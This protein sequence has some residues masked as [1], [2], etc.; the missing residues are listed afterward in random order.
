MVTIMNYFPQLPI[1]RRLNYVQPQSVQGGGVRHIALLLLFVLF[2]QMGAFAARN[3]YSNTAFGLNK[4]TITNGVFK[5]TD[6]NTGTEMT[7]TNASYVAYYNPSGK[8]Y[9][10]PY[11]RLSSSSSSTTITFKFTDPALSLHSISYETNTGY[12]SWWGGYNNTYTFGVSRTTGIE[13][14][15]ESTDGLT[16]SCT[17]SGVDNIQIMSVGFWWDPIDEIME[18]APTGVTK[19][20]TGT[21]QSLF[22]LNSTYYAK[23]GT[24]NGEI[25]YKCKYNKSNVAALSMLFAGGQGTEKLYKGYA[26]DVDTYTIK[27][28][29]EGNSF[30]FSDV[31]VMYTK[32]QGSETAPLGTFSSEITPMVAT[33][34]IE[35]SAKLLDYTGEP[36]A[37]VTAASSPN[38]KAYYKLSTESAW[39]ESIPTGTDAGDYVVYWYMESTNSAY[40][41]IGSMLDPNGP[42]VVSIRKVDITTSPTPP[43]PLTPVYNT[44]EQSLVSGGEA[45]G[46][47]IWYRVGDDGTWKQTA[48]ASQVGPYRVYWYVKG[49]ENHNDLGSETSPYGNVTTEIQ[50]ASYNMSAVKWTN[51]LFTYDG[52]AKQGG[53]TVSQLPSPD[54]STTY[55]YKDANNN[56]VTEAV[57]AGTYTVIASFTT[58]SSNYVN[59]SPIST[60]LTIEPFNLQGAYADSEIPDQE[61]IGGAIAPVSESSPVLRLKPAGL[62]IPY[63]AYT[64]TYLNNVNAGTKTA[65]ATLTANNSD[66]NYVGS[67]ALRFS[68][69]KKS[70]RVSTEA[71]SITYGETISSNTDKA[72]LS[73]AVMGHELSAVTLRPY[74]NYGIGTHENAIV[75]SDV[76]INDGSGNDVTAN[77]DITCPESLRGTLT[78]AV[79][80]GGGFTISGLQAEY[81]GDGTTAVTPDVS[82]MAEVAVY[83]GATKLTKGTDYT[84][85]YT[86]NIVAGTATATFTFQG[87]YEGSVS[88]DFVIYY[89]AETFSRQSAPQYNY[90]TYY[91]PS[92]ALH[93]TD[94]N[95]KVYYCTLNGDKTEVVLNEV[96]A[97]VINAGTPVMLSTPSTTK[98]VKL[99]A[100]SGDDAV[101]SG[102][103]A[104]TGVSAVAAIDPESKTYIFDGDDFVWAHKG[105]LALH[106]AYVDGADKELARQRLSI[107]FG[108]SEATS[109]NNCELNESGRDAWYD[110]MGNRIDCPTRKGLYILNGKKVVVK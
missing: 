77:Y 8:N 45:T 74:E 32:P 110:L 63:S 23:S 10:K 24:G 5:V 72:T 92:E 97:K 2:T 50:K 22:D 103:N 75:A 40:E 96:T 81:E 11:L 62:V 14:F 47:E 94:A 44:Q 20:Y 34:V 6:S 17:F 36:Q 46:G 108:D 1:S 39:Q 38:G 57:N 49:D 31:D 102:T 51:A 59:P 89:L 9:Y 76:H 35:P 98:S 4:G 73:G 58:S 53:V 67:K 87:N 109:I 60:T 21:S 82:S 85:S 70:V 93:V 101:Y 26:T 30:R 28:W 55:T 7:I 15:T 99:Y 83:D 25:G 33:D 43:T 54:I 48:T 42:I 18:H 104:L 64:A 80:A 86:N 71:Q 79:K 27:W 91:H 84:V 68:I 105:N 61:Y 29:Y 13:N 56:E 78:V 100:Y 88:Q 95:A 107:A 52:T 66:E 69:T 41:N 37:L 90:C 19:S 16:W 12:S 65:T 3:P 106:K